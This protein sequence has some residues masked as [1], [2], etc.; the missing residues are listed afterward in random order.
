MHVGQ[1]ASPVAFPAGSR[2]LFL[3]FLHAHP[4]CSAQSTMHAWQKPCPHG[5]N[6]DTIKS[7]EHIAPRGGV[8]Q[9]G[10]RSDKG[11]SHK[12]SDGREDSST[13]KKNKAKGVDWSAVRCRASTHTPTTR[14]TFFCRSA[15]L[16]APL[17][18]VLQPA[19]C[20]ASPVQAVPAAAIFGPPRPL[21]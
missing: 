16:R 2:L 12:W 4:F 20:A 13:Y 7:S 1:V 3:F 11:K 17:L 5:K 8:R 9:R 14:L 19:L 21:P 15:S 18:E 6:R 10:V